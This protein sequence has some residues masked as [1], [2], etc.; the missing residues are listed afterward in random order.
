MEHAL[1]DRRVDALLGFAKSFLCGFGIAG[2]GSSFGLLDPGLHLG[3]DGEVA[4]MPFAV[5]AIP[6]DL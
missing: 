2:G 5:L 3:L 6:L 1:G 4:C